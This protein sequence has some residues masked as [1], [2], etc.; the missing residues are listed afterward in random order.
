MCFVPC[1]WNLDC[2]KES[3]VNIPIRKIQQGIDPEEFKNINKFSIAGLDD[4]TF[5]FY[6]I[7]QWTERKHPIALLKAY[8]AAFR[9]N[10]NVALVLKTYR[11]DYSEHEKDAIKKSIMMVKQVT[12]MYG[13]P[14]TMLVLDM[15]SREEIL[16]LHKRG[17]CFAL[18]H[19]GEGWGMPH[20]EAGASGNAVLTTGMSGNM[21]FTTPDN[22][23][24]VDY[25]WTPVF[26]MQW[27]KW[28][29][30]G[31]QWWAE[32]DILQASE[33][34]KHIYHNR[35]E[36]KN[37]GKKLQKYILDNFSWSKVSRDMLNYIKEV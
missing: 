36:A 13:Y 28:Y 15:L 12:P 16:G 19:R 7:F 5:V 20:F 8:W 10:E 31:D 25:S 35:E 18:L 17:D 9:N 23:Y 33:Y 11:N 27:I 30:G 21:E 32:P 1:Q 4:D 34:M 29:A 2:Y 22:S 3:G 26:G 37:K 24:L 14:R 6:S